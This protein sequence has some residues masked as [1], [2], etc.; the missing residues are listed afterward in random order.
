MEKFHKALIVNEDQKAI[1]GW[2]EM[3]NHSSLGTVSIIDYLIASGY[4]SERT[5][6]RNTKCFGE[7]IT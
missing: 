2:W 1:N 4:P 3:E 7:V 6:T 5:D